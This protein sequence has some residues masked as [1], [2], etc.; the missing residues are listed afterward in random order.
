MRALRDYEG[1]KHITIIEDAQYFA[2]EEI[3]CYGYINCDDFIYYE[4]ENGIFL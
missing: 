4:V 2:P 1:I 3:F